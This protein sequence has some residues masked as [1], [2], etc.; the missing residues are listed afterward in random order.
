MSDFAEFVVEQGLMDLPLA[1]G[2]STWANNSSWSRLD[3]FWVSPE[4]DFSY[5]GLMQKKLLRACSDH[6]P[7]LLDRGCL[8][9]GKR[10]FKFENIWLKEEG[11]VEKVKIWW[12]SFQFFGSPSFVLAKKISALKWGI[13]RWYL[14]EFG[15]VGARHKASCEEL[16]MLDKIE[17]GRQLTEEEKARRTQISRE[18]E[19][20]ILQEEICWRQ[21]SRVR[22]LK[23]G[24]KC[25]KFF[26]L[27][28]NANH[29][30]N[31]IE[32]L[33][34]NSSSTLDPAI[35]SDHIVSFYNSLFTEPLSWRPRLDNLEFNM[36]SSIKATGLEDP[37]EE[38]EV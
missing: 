27:V 21:K 34:V 14:E 3:R 22:W 16:K 18:V 7:I 20:S 4:W 19:A 24:D 36:L 15:D 10:S 6:A 28:V 23:E 8:Q 30:N 26:H 13:K 11:F 35:I 9:I 12:D 2:E 38:R 5:L 37:F 25:T 29:R 1:G 17:E 32:P 31:T 33:I